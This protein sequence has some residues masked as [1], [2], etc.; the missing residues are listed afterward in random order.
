MAVPSVHFAVGMGVGTLLGGAAG[1]VRRRWL[2]PLPLVATACG[3]LALVPDIM[4]WG[5]GRLG[6]RAYSHAP[7]MNLFCFHPWLDQVAWLETEAMAALG[8][9][10][11]ALLYLAMACGYA[12]YVRWG[13][14]RVAE[15]PAALA[16]MRRAAGGYPPL[17]ALA[18]VLPLAVVGV[19][20]AWVVRTAEAPTAR[21]AADSRDGE[22]AWQR[23]VR[24]RLRVSPGPYLGWVRRVP[25]EGEWAVVDLGA[26]TEFSGGSASLLEVCERAQASRCAVVALADASALA[27]EEDRAAYA[28]ALAAARARFPQ[29]PVLGGLAWRPAGDAAAQATAVVGPQAGEVE[30]M[31]RL[32]RRL[33]DGSEPEAALRWLEEADRSALAGPA[34]FWVGDGRDGEAELFSWLRAGDAFL[35]LVGLSG[36]ERLGSRLARARWDPRV[37]E[38]GGLWDR[39]L[40]RG[41][42]L[43]C[44]AAA[45]GLRDPDRHYW[46]GEYARTHVWCPGQGAGELLAGLRGGCF[47]ADE[48]GLVDALHF[49][50]E[51]SPL[52]R[53]ARMGE[54]VRVA[55]GAGVSVRLELELPPTDFAGRANGI[56]EVELV[57]NFSGRPQVVRSFARVE[58][59]RSLRYAFPPAEDRNGGLGF[60]VRA[61]GRRRLEGGGQL[62]FYTNPIRVLVRDGPEPPAEER[63]P[64]P[65]REPAPEPPPEEGPEEGPAEPRQE[66]QGPPRSPRL[67]AVGL[68]PTAKPIRVEQFRQPPGEAWEAGEWTPHAGDRGPAMGDEGLQVRLRTT[69]ELAEA[70]RLHFLCYAADCPRLRVRL[71]TSS[72][73]GRPYQLVRELPDRQWTEVDVSLRED[74]R[75][76]GSRP[77]AL[78]PGAQVYVIEWQGR[79]VGPGASFH[80]ADFAVYEP[81]PWSR[82]AEARQSVERLGARREAVVALGAPSLA[83]QGRADAVGARLAGLRQSLGEDSAPQRADE[84]AAVRQELA[85]LAGEV[86][87]LR[88]EAAMARAFAVEAPRFAVGLESATRRVSGRNPALGFDGR[89]ARSHEL[90][91]A[92]GEAESFQVVVLALGQPLEAVEVAWSDFQPRGPGG[93]LPREAL[94]A[95][96]VEETA[97]P[98]RP[99][100]PPARTGSVPDR[101][102]P[103]APFDLPAGALKAV[104]LTVE[105]PGDLPPGDY[106][107]TVSVR[108]KGL[109]P[110]RLAVT[111]HRWGFAL[112]GRHL[113]VI[114]PVDWPAVRQHVGGEGAL[115][116]EHRRQLYRLLLRHRADPVLLMGDDAEADL[117]DVAFCLDQGADLAVLEQ[118]QTL[119]LRR[120]EGLRRAARYARRLW[121]SGRGRRA[122]AV[123]PLVPEGREGERFV[124]AV[125]DFARRHPVLRLVAGGEGN[126]PPQ[127][128]ASYWRRPLATQPARLPDPRLLD[129]RRTRTTRREAWDVG[130]GT[131]EFPQPNLT[132]A[133]RLAE[134]RVLPWLAWRYGVRGLVLAGAT[135]WG[136]SGVGEGLLLYPGPEGTLQPSLRLV[137]LRDGAEDYE[138]LRLLYDRRRLLRRIAGKTNGGQG[139]APEGE[140]A[141]ARTLAAADQALQRVEMAVGTLHRPLRDPRTLAELRRALGSA[142]Q[143]AEAAWWEQVDRAEDLPAP[144]TDVT[145]SAGQGVV[146][147]AWTRSP[148]EGVTAYNVYRSR[149]PEGGYV[150]VNPRPVSA[151]AYEDR[152]V[153]NGVTYYYVVRSCEDRRGVGPGSQPPAEA[154]P[155]P[156]PH[157][158]WLEMADLTPATVGPYTVKLRLEGPRTGHVVPLIRPQLDYAVADGAYEGFEDMVRLVGKTWEFR[159][160]DLGWRR[161][162]GQRLRFRVRLVDREGREVTPAVEREERIG[163]D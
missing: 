159:I 131:P 71:E 150:R 100:L 102:A 118:V 21:Q 126:P 44:A 46:P 123:L 109:E 76:V 61:R 146:T 161:R 117:A 7:V 13:L 64:V 11:I 34:V 47:W 129:V 49:E 67:A 55:P 54:V 39:F 73:G 157:V 69:I 18:G 143:R 111:V 94:R 58:S 43:W 50:L 17:V 139:Q 63:R 112:V 103:Y 87:A 84:L 80:V 120:D 5:L 149:Q 104:L 99:D 110:V 108:P 27:S 133:N 137:A 4:A 163:P 28:A 114:C 75:Q 20:L 36:G 1:A 140:Q 88:L 148:D 70:T 37:A 79:G 52:D 57:S 74:F 160:P 141:L 90:W 113:P 12:A 81:T 145:A 119:D 144:P 26:H 59:G 41:F 48:G 51:A 138:C 29:T 147:L 23:L 136:K 115:E 78:R 132:W 121:E 95:H 124:D 62:A 107:G 24:S 38:A 15:G 6:A 152:S 105:V 65:R 130:A 9:H 97:V 125:S 106:D 92:G 3:V 98:A 83:W 86:R 31:G 101:L 151:L 142:L 33:G 122:A 135:R 153:E 42:R 2:I 116:A 25:R 93:P 127:L 96:L 155:R 158:V 89:I 85:S 45:S 68:P 19:A 56:D 22:A 156:A 30:R 10:V 16:R 72:L 82:V 60:Y 154:T 128:L 35:G 53:P 14:G 91:A 32:A 66:P 8:F 134:A 40:D 77:E 162:A